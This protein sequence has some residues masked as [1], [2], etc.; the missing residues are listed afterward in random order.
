MKSFKLFLPAFITLCIAVGFRSTSTKTSEKMENRVTEVV[1]YKIKP[2]AVSEMATI[3]KHVN[4]HATRFD[5]FISRKVYQSP[6]DPTLLMDQVEW[7]SLETAEAAAKELPQ[8]P[9]FVPFMQLID[10]VVSFQ[11]FKAIS[12]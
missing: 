7:Q 9:E 3:I 12:E 8:K 2:E 11:H 6:H 4:Q 10:S 5:G 1:I